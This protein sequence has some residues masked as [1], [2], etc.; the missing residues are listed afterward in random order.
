MKTSVLASVVLSTLFYT[1]LLSTTLVMPLV[2]AAG[3]VAGKPTATRDAEIWDRADV[4]AKVEARRDLRLLQADPP[5]SG[6]A[7]KPAPIDQ[8]GPDAKMI[9]PGKLRAKTIKV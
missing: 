4:P 9:K 1:T 2:L 5:V 6:A 8:S 7:A 3:G